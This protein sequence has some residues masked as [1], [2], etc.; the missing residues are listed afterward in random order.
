MSRKAQRAENGKKT[1]TIPVELEEEPAHIKSYTKTD[2]FNGFDISEN[3]I[4]GS[5]APVN[6]ARGGRQSDGSRCKLTVL[7]TSTR[8]EVVTHKDDSKHT[9]IRV[10]GTVLDV[11][12]NGAADTLVTGTGHNW[13]F[14][15]VPCGEQTENG[16]TFKLREPCWNGT[17][18]A[19]D[20]YTFSSSFYK[21]GPGNGGAAKPTDA[22]RCKPGMLV[23]V[24]GVNAQAGVSKTGEP[25][26]YLNASRIDISSTTAP[27]PYTLGP[28]M[29][30]NCVSA[31]MAELS[32][33]NTSITSGGYFGVT[34]LS[35]EQTTQALACQAKWTK[36]HR[37]VVS[38]LEEMARGKTTETA[39]AMKTRA[40]V[41]DNTPASNFVSDENFFLRDPFNGP[42]AGLVQCGQSP[43]DKTPYFLHQLSKGGDAAK[44]VPNSFVM[45]NLVGYGVTGN[46]ITCD[47]QPAFCFDKQ[48][49]LEAYSQMGS[50]N[51]SPFITT[52][53]ATISTSF[54]LKGMAADVVGTRCKVKAAMGMRELMPILDYAT[55]VKISVP[56][57]TA[58]GTTLKSD[59]TEGFFPVVP[60]TLKRCA[61]AVSENFVQEN[62]C[63][64]D[65]QY[66]PDAL[67]V[68]EGEEGDDDQFVIES[69]PMLG[70]HHFQQLTDSQ[71]TFKKFAA[72]AKEFPDKELAY[73]VVYRNMVAD[74]ASNKDLA[75]ND[76]KAEMWLGE[77][78]SSPQS[79][80]GG[81][82][83]RPPKSLAAFIKEDCLVYAILV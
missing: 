59:W 68:K 21:L 41:I 44:A 80:P 81:S 30:E 33:L 55:I 54:S 48:A 34:D 82:M 63:D 49:A 65:L 57:T 66:S 52:P 8:E 75:T 71:F 18:T 51:V 15:T 26:V 11:N 35:P 32:A 9:K 25:T 72:V 79:S 69:L 64:G 46:L 29:I 76:D 56:V 43:W 1:P 28:R 40:S 16:K 6:H 77:Q 67:V 78:A 13:L 45:F 50:N 5:A 73:R 53:N 7:V 4:F 22:A 36:L 24:L 74:L 47:Y 62:L 17:Q 37:A 10:S 14:P 2:P 23:T 61:V 27:V 58:A 42:V 39:E 70:S 12:P 83:T 60:E 19:T 31:K 20:L 3:S 38:G